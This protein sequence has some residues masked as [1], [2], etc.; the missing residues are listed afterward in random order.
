MISGE[1]GMELL[2]G[3]DHKN[4]QSKL[5]KTIQLCIEKKENMKFED[6][7]IIKNS[8]SLW[9]CLMAY[10]VELFNDFLVDESVN[11]DQFI[12]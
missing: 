8:F 11:S 5:I 1:V 2:E 9:I 3:I 10:N 4:L 6:V 7:Q 12:L